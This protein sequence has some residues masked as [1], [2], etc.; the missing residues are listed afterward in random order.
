[1]TIAEGLGRVSSLAVDPNSRKVY[2]LDYAKNSLNM[3]VPGS[4][5]QTILRDLNSPRQLSYNPN[6]R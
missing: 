4:N 6:T 5:P 3:V 2:F 1:M